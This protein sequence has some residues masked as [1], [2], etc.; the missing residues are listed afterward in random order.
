MPV[1][2][3]GPYLDASV[4]SILAQTFAELELVVLDDGSTDG[5]AGQLRDWAKRDS[6]IRLVETPV[7][8]GLPRGS[9]RV[10]REARAP[11]CA[12][13]DADDVACPTRLAVQWEVLQ[14]N[15]DA[16]LVGTL[17]EGIDARGRLVRPRDR[18]R[19][20]RRSSF[21]PFPH[22][23]I[24]FRREVFDAVGGYRA[25]CDYWEDLDL[26]LRMATRGR[27]LVV[28]EPLYRYRFHSASRL[29]G[30]IAGDEERAAELMLRCL[31]VRGAGGD[32]A[33]LLASAAEA[34]GRP[35]SPAALYH[36]AA[37]RLWAGRR[38]GILRR[39][40]AVRPSR[41]SPLWLGLLVLATAGE[42]APR[43]VRAA[44]ATFIRL[45]DARA[46]RLVPDGT[47][48]EWRFE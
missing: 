47:P 41:P 9:D 2:N 38:P 42:L 21:A 14:A 28:P 45:R 15:P 24:M 39:L 20:T 26:Y 22:G 34:D 18:W 11:V 44:L 29:G 16:A 23:S 8:L 6:R 31:A 27:V 7:R 35:L 5:S 12:R 1:R 32:Y 37:R 30:D 33:P 3:A 25:A 43:L 13:M 36:L 48:V 19:L 10:V 17:W 46:G 40:G 4:E